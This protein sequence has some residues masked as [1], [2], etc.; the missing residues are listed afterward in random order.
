M[1]EKTRCNDALMFG[2]GISTMAV[3]QAGVHFCAKLPP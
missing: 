3:T 1:R 2:I